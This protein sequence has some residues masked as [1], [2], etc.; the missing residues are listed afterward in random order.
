M[1]NNGDKI[2]LS[3]IPIDLAKLR[4]VKPGKNQH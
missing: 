2:I 3:L 1:L 4:S